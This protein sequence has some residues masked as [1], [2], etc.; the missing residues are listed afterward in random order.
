MVLGRLEAEQGSPERADA[1]TGE[2]ARIVSGIASD[3]E[4]AA[5]V[6]CFTSRPLFSSIR[7]R[8]AELIEEV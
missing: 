4:A 6:S 8:V 5:D 7:D 3:L 1:L 2:A